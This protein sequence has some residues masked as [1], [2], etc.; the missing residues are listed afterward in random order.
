MID[1]HKV[2]ADFPI[3]KE[4]VNGKQLVYLDNVSAG[5]Y[6]YTLRV[7]NTGGNTAR[8]LILFPNI[9]FVELKK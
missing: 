9:S 5:T 3:L 1:I 6:T 8:T 4:K 2:R 7:Q